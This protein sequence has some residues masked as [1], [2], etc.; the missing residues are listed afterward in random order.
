M[1]ECESSRRP[2]TIKQGK[3]TT[4]ATQALERLSVADKNELLFQNG[5]NFN[6]VPN[7][8]KRGVGLYW[9]EY[10]KEGVN[11]LTGQTVT[12]QR[13]R[14]RIEYELPMKE[15]YTEFIRRLLRESDEG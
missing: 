15:G 8:Q 9:E 14:I 10:E 13:R 7:W 11:P 4:Q 5:I 1:R 6:E 3:S 12:A 2:T